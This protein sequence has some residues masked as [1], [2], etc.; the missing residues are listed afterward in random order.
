MTDGYAPVS[1][2]SG[3]A[4]RR[5]HGALLV[6]FGLIAIIAPFSVSGWAVSILGLVVIMAGAAQVV[7]GLRAPSAAS[8]WATP[9]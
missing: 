8:T 2:R 9:T 1:K 6:G 3:Y 7:E 5:A 4:S